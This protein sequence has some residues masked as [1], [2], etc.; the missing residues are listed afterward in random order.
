MENE[1]C[2]FSI[3]KFILGRELKREDMIDLLNGKK[4]KMYQ[5]KSKG[6]KFNAQ[7]MLQDDKLKF[8]FEEKSY[9]KSNNKKSK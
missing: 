5:F 2:S 3:N 7:L 4:T 6:K 1:N 9:G 8:I